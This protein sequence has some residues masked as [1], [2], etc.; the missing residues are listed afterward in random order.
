MI[1]K[2]TQTHIKSV[3]NLSGPIPQTSQEL[4]CCFLQQTGSRNEGAPPH[5]QSPKEFCNRSCDLQPASSQ[6][7]QSVDSRC[8]HFGPTDMDSVNEKFCLAPDLKMV[9]QKKVANDLKS[10]WHHNI[11]YLF[12]VE[13]DITFRSI[14]K[15][16]LNV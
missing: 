9:R 5:F 16:K 13:S 6:E 8:F 7:P 2:I 12:F 1:R 10:I 11:F 3:L 4:F 14:T 15:H